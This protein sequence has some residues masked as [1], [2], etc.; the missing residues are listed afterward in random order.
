MSAIGTQ[1][2][3]GCG[4]CSAIDAV[5]GCTSLPR[6]IIVVSSLQSWCLSRRRFIGR[7]DAARSGTITP[8]ELGGHH[9]ADVGDLVVGDV[10]GGDLR[11]P[12]QRVV[13]GDREHP[14]LVRE[15]RAR[16]RGP[17]RRPGASPPSGPPRRGAAARSG[18]TARSSLTSTP[19]PGWRSSNAAM[20][21]ISPGP[22]VML[23]RRPMRSVASCVAPWRTATRRSWAGAISARK[24]SPAAVSA[25]R[26]LV[27]WTRRSPSLCSSCAGSGS[28]ATA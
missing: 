22:A 8:S 17:A 6:A 24:R 15:R 23:V 5:V 18:P 7:P 21:S 19:Q 27:R 26:R 28:R 10:V 2:M 11:P 13:G 4:N 20:S 9:P 16:P 25:T 1:R 3:P 12:A 14:R